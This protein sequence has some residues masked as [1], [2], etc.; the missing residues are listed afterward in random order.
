MTGTLNVNGFLKAKGTKLVN[1]AGEEVFLRGINLGNWFLPE[2]YMW[3]VPHSLGKHHIMEKVF[4]ELLGEEKANKFWETYFNTYT[5]ESDI[6][7]IKEEGFNSIRLPLNYRVFMNNDRVF[8]ENHIKIIDRT[9]DWCEK[10]GIY[11]ILDLHGAPGGQTGTNIDDS[12]NN[13]PDLFADNENVELTVFFWK[14]LAERYKDRTIIGGYDLL[15]EPVPKEHKQY[16]DKLIDV[17]KKIIKAIREV[18]NNHLIILECSNWATDF[19]IFTE[20]HDDNMVIQFHKYWCPIDYRFVRDYLNIRETLNLP[21]WMGESGENTL[22]WYQ[23]SFQMLEDYNISWCFWPW[24][25]LAAKNNPCSIKVPEG[26]DK[27]GNHAKGDIQLSADEAESILNELLE[28][29]KFENCEYNQEVLN[30]L[31]RRAPFRIQAEYYQLHGV[32][33]SYYFRDKVATNVNFRREEGLNV[34]FI[35]GKDDELPQFDS[36]PS[37]HMPENERLY[38][39]LQAGDWVKYEVNATEDQFIDLS[40]HIA[41]ETMDAVI[42]L[43]LNSEVNL[44]G[45]A[46]IENGW[47][48]QT[49]TEK[50][51]LPA[52][53]HE[54]K[55]IVRNGIVKVDYFDIK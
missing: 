3:K 38:I 9:L 28:N 43:W 42:E 31:F 6:K 15:N 23:G 21:L 27:L 39:S 34:K 10:Y 49:L 22:D 17:Y 13:Y 32:G 2:A 14:S 51:L 48:I 25:K 4:S 8:D 52:G 12:L 30:A 5:M 44:T 26:W 45:S 20:K 36:D 54:L 33:Q 1:G 29:I 50:A 11:C 40:A 35:C 19:R 16:H 18:D 41:A 46:V 53:I 7:K 24:K 37:N 55:L 47:H